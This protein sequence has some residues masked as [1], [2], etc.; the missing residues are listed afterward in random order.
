MDRAEH[1]ALARARQTQTIASRDCFPSAPSRRVFHL[2]RRLRRRRAER[3]CCRRF[4]K[5]PALFIP[6]ATL[7]MRSGSRGPRSSRLSRALAGPLFK[8][9]DNARA[10]VKHRSVTLNHHASRF[11]PAGQPPSCGSDEGIVRAVWRC[12]IDFDAG[13]GNAGREGWKVGD[14]GLNLL[15]R[16][17]QFPREVA[18][19]PLGNDD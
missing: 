2:R 5:S 16:P 9:R 15:R 6:R 19:T 18:R 1:Q 13:L 7:S 3:V 12:G 17:H 14:R 4:R 11:G 8:R 10:G